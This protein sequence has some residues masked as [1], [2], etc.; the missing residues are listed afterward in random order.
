VR[1]DETLTGGNAI[2]R[3]VSGRYITCKK[4]AT[5]IIIDAHG[6]EQ[7]HIDQGETYDM[8][9]RF[10]D[11]VIKIRSTET[12]ANA[13]LLE[14]TENKLL[15]SDNKNIS[16]STTATIEGSNENS[17][18]PKVTV[19]DG[20]GAVVIALANSSRKSIRVAVPSDAPG[21]IAIGK[22]GLMADQGGLME[23]GTIDYIDTEGALYARTDNG[24]GDVE[25]WVMELNRV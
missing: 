25:V 8:G 13:I 14:V 15:K 18:L 5:E 12:G 23:P 16:V 10:Q 9:A 22:A 19:P 24:F 4:A 20:G 3:P 2:K 1:I 11:K 6:L 21:P 7:V 17:H